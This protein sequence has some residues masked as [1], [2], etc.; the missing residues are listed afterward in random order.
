MLLF[1]LRVVCS[2]AICEIVEAGSK[3]QVVV[4]SRKII[5]TH[6]ANIGDYSS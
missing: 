2:R 4:N 1:A 6:P 5:D 3:K